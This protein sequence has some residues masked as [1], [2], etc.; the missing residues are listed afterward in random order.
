MPWRN[1][2]NSSNTSGL[3]GFGQSANL[4][5]TNTGM[6]ANYGASLMDVLGNIQGMSMG[7]NT[8]KPDASTGWL[9]S[10]N[11]NAPGL[12]LGLG[13]LNTLGGLYQSNRMLSLAKDQFRH[14]RDTTNTNLTNQ[15]QSYNTAL[16][17]RANARGVMEGRDQDSIDKYIT[18]NRLS[19]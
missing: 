11:K 14:A 16:T 2:Q 13:A 5:G 7:G 12:Q 3:Y 19:R 8:A 15:I 1:Q 10:L 9:A 6:P 18:E 4:G 17:D